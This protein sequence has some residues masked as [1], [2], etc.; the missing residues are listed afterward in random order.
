MFASVKGDM[1]ASAAHEAALVFPPLLGLGF[2]PAMS[3]TLS[4]RGRRATA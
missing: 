3:L 4:H 1:A 2:E